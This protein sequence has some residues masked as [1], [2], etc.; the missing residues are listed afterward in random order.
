MNMNVDGDGDGK[1]ERGRGKGERKN[2]SKGVL[3]HEREKERESWIR[4]V[5]LSEGLKKGIIVVVVV[6]VSRH[7]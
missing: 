1:G 7:A 2:V 5:P 6:L 4:R 3:R